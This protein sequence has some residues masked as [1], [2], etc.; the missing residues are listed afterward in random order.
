LHA[1]LIL[2]RL[3]QLEE[4]EVIDDDQADWQFVSI[5]DQRIGIKTSTLEEKRAACEMLCI[6]ARQ[7][8]PMFA[9][10]VAEILPIS[11]KLLKFYFEDGVRFYSAALMPFLIG[12]LKD[13]P[14]R[15]PAVALQTW[16]QTIANPLMEVGRV[17][18]LLGEF[19]LHKTIRRA[20]VLIF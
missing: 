19:F 9:P 12:A 5:E 20:F 6:Y 8:G 4:D 17:V 2:T 14:T 10:Y 13:D 7:L 11:L 15:G 18:A 1:A 16:M 3:S